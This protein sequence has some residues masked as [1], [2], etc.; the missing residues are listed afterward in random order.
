[1]SR[2]FYIL[3]L[4]LLSVDCWNILPLG[5][6]VSPT[7]WYISIFVW[8]IIGLLFMKNRFHDYLWKAGGNAPF[9]W[10]IIGVL[11][12]FLP[13]KLYYAQSFTMSMVTS[14]MMLVYCALPVIMAIRPSYSDLRKAFYSFAILFLAITLLDSISSVHIT[15][16]RE[17]FYQ[18]DVHN[19]LD[20]IAEG[21]FVHMLSGLGLVLIAYSFS[22]YEYVR[23]NSMKHLLMMLVLYLAISINLNRSTILPSTLLLLY[24]LL[25]SKNKRNIV[26]Y[27]II[28]LIF[29]TVIIQTQYSHIVALINQTIEDVNNTDYNRNMAYSYFLSGFR[30]KPLCYLLGT[31]LI[32]SHASS[33]VS[34]LQS[35]GIH[36]SDVGLIGMWNLYGIIPIIVVLLFVVKTFFHKSIPLQCKFIAFFIVLCSPT[37]SFFCQF[38]EQIMWLVF[39][40]YLYYYYEKDVEGFTISHKRLLR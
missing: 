12:S 6:I 23:E 3:I 32:S 39:F 26:A 2:A 20:Y 7:G 5:R 18:S 25:F 24:P 13:S 35:S 21:D 10:I 4:L 22:V 11:C 29:I 33:Y 1:M 28:S 19:N 27:L 15:Y 14:R 8:L 36:N 9:Y 16:N 30:D 37:I 38:P 31:G 17:L 34:T 40:I